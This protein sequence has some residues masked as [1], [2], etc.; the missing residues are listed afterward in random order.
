MQDFITVL[1]TGPAVDAFEHRCCG[2]N[3]P[4]IVAP[5]TQANIV[6]LGHDLKLKALNAQL[7][8]FQGQL[9]D[10]DKEISGFGTQSTSFWYERDEVLK[11][12]SDTEF[13]IAWISRSEE[14]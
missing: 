2:K 9:A 8:T 14:N 7:A 3:L 13:E 12:I 4:A 1:P 5:D 10:M 11:A 6:R